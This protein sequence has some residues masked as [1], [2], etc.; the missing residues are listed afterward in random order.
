MSAIIFNHEDA[1]IG[2]FGHEV[3]LKTCPMRWCQ[4]DFGRASILRQHNFQIFLEPLAPL[5]EEARE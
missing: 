4:F 2:Q 1:A 3:R 5:I